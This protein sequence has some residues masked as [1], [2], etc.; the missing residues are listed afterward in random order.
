MLTY[1]EDLRLRT[2]LLAG[3]R[4]GTD[5]DILKNDRHCGWVRSKTSAYFFLLWVSNRQIVAQVINCRYLKLTLCIVV[6]V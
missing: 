6:L 3:L 2:K 4:T 5:T 1:F